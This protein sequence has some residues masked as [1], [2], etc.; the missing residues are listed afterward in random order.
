VGS[1]LIEIDLVPYSVR[2]ELPNWE[3]YNAPYP[4]PLPTVETVP[5]LSTLLA[6]SADI[7]AKENRKDPQ[8]YSFSRDTGL[9]KAVIGGKSWVE[10]DLI[11][12][13]ITEG[14][15]DMDGDGFYEII[16]YYR[17]AKLIRITYDGNQN[18]IPEYIEEYEDTPMRK[19]DTDEDGKV[20][21]QMQFENEL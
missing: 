5:A 4:V 20:E 9:L 13:R 19:W 6:K 10:S 8:T 17:D 12:G 3:N 15:R 7:R 14:R 21:Y 16:E 1:S 2:Y 18:G 11:S